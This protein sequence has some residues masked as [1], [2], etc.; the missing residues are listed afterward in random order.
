MSVGAYYAAQQNQPIGAS[1]DGLG[2]VETPRPGFAEDA[3]NHLLAAVTTVGGAQSSPTLGLYTPWAAQEGDVDWQQTSA[4][5]NLLLAPLTDAHLAM[6]K[7]AAFGSPVG[8]LAV[9]TDKPS[10]LKLASAA[11]DDTPYEFFAGEA[12][13]RQDDKAPTPRAYFLYWAKL[14]DDTGGGSGSLGSVAKALGGQLVFPMQ[15]PLGGKEREPPLAFFSAALTAQLR[16]G[17]ATSTADPRLALPAAKQASVAPRVPWLVLLGVG[18]A[19]AV[20]GW[21]LVKR[22]RNRNR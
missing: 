9:L 2:A 11:F 13:Y 17:P 15:M 1:P 3:L 22:N 12:V 5:W 18:G 20:G 4:S 10:T 16:T 14:R 6:A 7:Q 19:A 8:W 21:W